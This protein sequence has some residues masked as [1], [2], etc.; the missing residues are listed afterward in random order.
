M[1]P[2]YKDIEAI[3]NYV[4][5]LRLENRQLLLKIENLEKGALKLN[6]KLEEK[7]REIALLKLE[8]QEYK[9]A[10]SQREAMT[11]KEKLQLRKDEKIERLQKKITAYQEQVKQLSED[12]NKLMTK[13]LKLQQ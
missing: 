1:K 4:N 3:K 5:A 12:K 9:V 10:A 11:D 6:D 13:Y 8:K 2:D 7:D